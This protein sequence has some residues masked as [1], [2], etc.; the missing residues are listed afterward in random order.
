[1]P[2][3][4]APAGAAT[5][6]PTTT[7]GGLTPS[8]GGQQLDL[9]A[10][11]PVLQQ[12]ATALTALTQALQGAGAVTAGGAAGAPQG[13]GAQGGGPPAKGGGAMAGMPGMGHDGHGEH[14]GAHNH[15]GMSIKQRSKPVDPALAQRNL[16]AVYSTFA[17]HTRQGLDFKN[18]QTHG[19]LSE[20]ER[21]AFRRQNPGL[22]VPQSLVF[23]E[24]SN[25][26]IGAVY[27][28]GAGASGDFD[29]GMG[30]RHA[31][32]DHPGSEMQ[33]IWFTPNNLQFAFSDVE[34]GMTGTTAA[35]MKKLGYPT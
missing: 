22:H 6:A 11:V 1:M 24:G 30:D 27:R 33:H 9:N 12:L 2:P 3:S 23:R 8:A 15:H 14:A 25:T 10:L 31:H 32:N 26:P 13:G 18:N 19:Y 28:T 20:Q 21:S 35:A 34:H 4:T 17:K 5:P 29:L 7:G 16:D